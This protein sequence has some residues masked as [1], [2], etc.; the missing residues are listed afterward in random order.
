MV[1]DTVHL[2]NQ[3]Y[4]NFLV[5]CNL[6]YENIHK[7]FIVT[8]ALQVTYKFSVSKA[9]ISQ[10]LPKYKINIKTC[11]HRSAESDVVQLHVG[12]YCV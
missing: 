1:L 4:L 9:L 8:E 10:N 11:C 2:L 12:D 3:K 5:R 6:V 7:L